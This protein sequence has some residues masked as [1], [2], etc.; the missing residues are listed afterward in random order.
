M[1]RRS[2]P[3]GFTYQVEFSA[4]DFPLVREEALLLEFALLSHSFCAFCVSKKLL[5]FERLQL[6][7]PLFLHGLVQLLILFV[8]EGQV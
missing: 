5:F 7:Q 4:E 6:S 1:Y 3:C 8:E 2:A